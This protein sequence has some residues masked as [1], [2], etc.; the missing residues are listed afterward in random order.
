MLVEL[1]RVLRDPLYR[2]EARRY[3]TARR[4]VAAVHAGAGVI[5]L[6]IWARWTRRAV[7]RVFLA[8]EPG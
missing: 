3:W 5:A 1:R 4:Y 7:E 2:W 6:V 8:P